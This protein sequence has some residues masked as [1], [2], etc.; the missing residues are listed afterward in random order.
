MA[1]GATIYFGSAESDRQITEIARLF[2]E[3]H[4]L[5]MVTAL[6]CYLRNR[7]FKRADADYHLSTDLPGQ[8]NYL[9]VTIQADMIKQKLPVNN[10][11]YKI[12]NTEDVTYGKKD[13]RMCTKLST[14]HPMD[15]C[16]YQVLNC[17]MGRAGLTNSGGASEGAADLKEAVITAII[18][19]R[20]GCMGL[21]S[22]RKAFQ[23]SLPEGIE[24]L[25]AIQDIYLEK[26]ITVA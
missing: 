14:D 19:K 9:N 6:W 5:G 7:V 25:N 18:N 13:E 16:R 8:A 20:A 23:H 24:L 11:G 10:G 12:L 3:A 17:Y 15:L 21:T 4:S 1:V 26:E 22:G 2:E